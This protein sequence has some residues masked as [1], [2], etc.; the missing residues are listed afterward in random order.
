MSLMRASKATVRR[1]LL[2]E[3]RLSTA[4]AA[5]LLARATGWHLRRVGPVAQTSAVE[6]L[7]GPI[8]RL[9]RVGQLASRL[10]LRA[11]RAFRLLGSTR[12]HL[13]L[14]IYLTI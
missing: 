8:H 11:T 9:V 3:R 10:L 12:T 2:L 5:T 6:A 4:E 13:E 7:P 14:I 1:E